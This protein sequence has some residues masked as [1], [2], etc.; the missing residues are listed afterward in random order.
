M[1]SIVQ[2]DERICYLCG[3]YSPTDVHHIFGG[4]ANRKKSDED[5]MVIKVHRVCHEWIHTHELSDLNLKAKAQRIW[6][7]HYG[8][9]DEDFIER[10]GINYV[11]KLNER[12]KRNE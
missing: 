7:E 8:K 12:L 2:D 9:S 1:K 10:Y 6:C 5:S 4:T 3:R 11:E